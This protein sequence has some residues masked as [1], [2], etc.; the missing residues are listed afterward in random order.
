M[1]GILAG[2]AEGNVLR[3]VL[4]LHSNTDIL[5][6]AY[7]QIVTSSGDTAIM[8]IGEST[9]KHQERSEYLLLN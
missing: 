3:L 8:I 6:V 5:E 2:V 4:Y 1:G 9:K 7:S